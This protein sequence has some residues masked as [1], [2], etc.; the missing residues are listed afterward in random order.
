MVQ[1]DEHPHTWLGQNVQKA[2]AVN[3]RIELN[4][5]RCLLYMY[6]L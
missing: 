6:M 1:L 2:Y 3:Q 5:V 4:T